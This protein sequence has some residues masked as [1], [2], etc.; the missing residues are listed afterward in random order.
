MDWDFGNTFKI[1]EEGLHVQGRK[2][3]KKPRKPSRPRQSGILFDKPKSKRGMRFTD[4][5][6]HNETGWYG[7][8]QKKKPKFQ[9]R[10]SEDHDETGW[11]GRPQKEKP[12]FQGRDSEDHDETGWYVRPQKEKKKPRKPSRSRQ[13]GILFDKPKSKRGMRFTD[14]ED[15]DETGWYGRPQKKKPKFQ[16][17]DS[18]DHGAP[19]WGSQKSRNISK[20]RKLTEKERMFIKRKRSIP[21]KTRRRRPMD[22]RTSGWRIPKRKTKRGFTDS[23]DYD[24]TPRRKVPQRKKEFEM[25]LQQQGIWYDKP[26]EGP[27]TWYK[28]QQ[29]RK[30]DKPQWKID[31]GRQISE[32]EDVEFL[33]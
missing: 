29:F 15:H 3:K 8:P 12:K 16:G 31:K 21:I 32:S 2:K 18:E 4:S 23:E 33:D 28:D 10:D 27:D 11:Y 5:E 19:M 26:R 6:D 13:S 7:R 17:R 25:S 1:G 22:S 30:D 20:G 9:G 24:E 14:S